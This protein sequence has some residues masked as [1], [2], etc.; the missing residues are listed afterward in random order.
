MK[1]LR[2]QPLMDDESRYNYAVNYGAL[3]NV[4]TVKMPLENFNAKDL[5][6]FDIVLLPMF[7]RWKGNMTLLNEIKNH[8]I[9]KVLFDNDSCY[10]SFEDDFYKGFDF[11][12]YRCHDRDGNAPFTD[13]SWL[14]WSINTDKYK[15]VY[16]GNGISFNC[17]IKGYELRE[18]ISRFLTGTSYTGE[19]YIKHLQDSAAGIHTGSEKVNVTRA[20]VLEFAA[21]GMNIISTRTDNLEFYFPENYITLF[22]DVKEL[23][24]IIK[25]FQPDLKIQK[26]LRE[27]THEFHSDKRKGK[28]IWQLLTEAI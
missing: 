24:E 21:C 25:H 23:K 4:D 5:K 26:D 6:E 19:A 17:S 8:K 3:D 2:L 15:P 12:F 18:K 11:I 7:S 14:P 10:R 28:Y 22:D 27:I 20:K 1:A 9:K 16:G 13:S